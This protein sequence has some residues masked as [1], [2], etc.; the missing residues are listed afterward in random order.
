MYLGNTAIKRQLMKDK[1]VVGD[2]VNKRNVAALLFASVGGLLLIVTGYHGVST[3]F[4][5]LA[6][7]IAIS[8]SPDPLITNILLFGLSLLTFFSFLGGWTVL[9]GCLLLLIGR[10]RSSFYFI[11]IGAGLSLMGLVWNLFQI[12]VQSAGNPGIFMNN[13]LLFFFIRYQGLA[14]FGAIFAVIGQELIQIGKDQAEEPVDIH[15][16]QTTPPE[17]ADELLVESSEPEAVNPLPGDKGGSRESN[18]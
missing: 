6:I 2:L 15:T 13:F 10:R 5:G 1:F 11:G 18:S 7:Q 12:W 14:W 17:S 9:I 8:L 3:G 4:W 16:K